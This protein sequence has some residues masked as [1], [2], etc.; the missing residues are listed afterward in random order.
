MDCYGMKM[1][2]PYLKSFKGGFLIKGDY[3]KVKVNEA[4][5][6][7]TEA[8]LSEMISKLLVPEFYSS[9]LKKFD[10]AYDSLKVLNPAMADLFIRPSDLVEIIK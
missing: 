8:N 2:V 7:K 10:I 3:E 4:S 6:T 1:K 9:N 5:C